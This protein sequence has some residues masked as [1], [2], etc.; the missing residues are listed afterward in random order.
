MRLN[1][2]VLPAVWEI[3]ND[4]AM[5]KKYRL[6]FSR[7][8]DDAFNHVRNKALVCDI[9]GILQLIV[10]SRRNVKQSDVRAWIPFFERLDLKDTDFPQ[11]Y[12]KGYIANHLSDLLRNRKFKE[13]ELAQ[14]A[15]SPILRNWMLFSFV[16][17]ET[18][19]PQNY[20]G[21]LTYEFNPEN[22]EEETFKKS[23][24][25]TQ[26]YLE[27]NLVM[28]KKWSEALSRYPT[29]E[30]YFP[31]INGRVWAARF[32]NQMLKTG[33][34]QSDLVQDW[35]NDLKDRSLVLVMLNA[36]EALPILV[37][38]GSDQTQIQE[39]LDYVG[40]AQ[41]LN[42]I[43]NPFVASLENAVYLASR[44][45]FYT[46]F[47]D[48]IRAQEFRTKL[49]ENLCLPSYSNYLYGIAHAF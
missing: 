45:A 34:L 6:D 29:D 8:A 21:R 5:H 18:L 25:L 28:M 9:E 30:S 15:N 43:H 36:L 48:P 12:L 17:Y 10:W 14:I 3:E 7:V 49:Y 47:N 40:Y 11:F 44:T 38:Y 23:V 4:P 46:R 19:Q 20:Y 1:N 26:Y 24:I 41:H 16:D 42:V 13:K 39:V 27:G 32:L 31:I 22:L 37:R 35:F 33:Q 2:I